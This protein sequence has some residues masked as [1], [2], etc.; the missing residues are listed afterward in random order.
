MQKLLIYY[1]RLKI[2]GENMS[3]A[4]VKIDPET[5][6]VANMYMSTMSLDKTAEML[7]LHPMEVSEYI[8]KPAVVRYINSVM[9]EQGYM[10]R[11]TLGNAISSLIQK[12]MIELEENEIG[13]NKDIADLIKLMMDFMKLM[14]TQEDK[15]PSAPHKQTNIQINSHGTNYEN[16][17]DKLVKDRK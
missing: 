4:L 10:N 8:N 12:K 11:Y 14:Q 6:E 2:K 16:L 5:L 17:I 7:G 9:M 15:T 3:T 13:S 1:D